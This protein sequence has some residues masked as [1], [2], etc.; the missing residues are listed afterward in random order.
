[1][2]L[3]FAESHAIA[4]S[5]TLCFSSWKYW[6]APMLHAKAMAVVVAYDIYKECCDGL[7]RAGEWKIEKPVSFHLFRE[8]LA[9]QMLRYNPRDR[10]YVG[11]ERFR[12]STQ[13]H[14]KIAG[15]V[16][17]LLICLVQELFR[18]RRLPLLQKKQSKRLPAHVCVAIF[19]HS[20][21]TRKASNKYQTGMP[22]FVWCVVSFAITY[23]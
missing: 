5:H 1:M 8:K 21:I 4:L 14:T 15:K 22:K 7:M 9:K 12:T 20:L 3:S 10:K 17:C 2:L 13:Q 18:R 6:H 19:A 11:D 16:P 23:A